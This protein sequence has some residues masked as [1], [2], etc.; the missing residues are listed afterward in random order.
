MKQPANRS[1]I[2]DLMIDTMLHS[3]TYKDNPL[4]SSSENNSFAIQ[5]LLQIPVEKF[6]KKDRERILKAW[7]P[8]PENEDAKDF[9]Y[10]STALDA[11]VLSLKVKIMSRPTF[12]KVCCLSLHT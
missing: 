12:Y 9:T 8:D 11:G 10:E 2:V 3:K 6:T 7:L 1:H 4:V 5:S